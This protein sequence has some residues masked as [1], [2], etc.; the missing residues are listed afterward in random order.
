MN[1]YHNVELFDGSILETIDFSKSPLKQKY[2]LTPSHAGEGLTMRPLRSDDYNKGYLDLLGQLTE[3]GD[4]SQEKF[5]EQ[6]HRM[7]NCKNNYFVIIIEDVSN[8]KIVA[9]GTLAVEH[10]FI[11]RT[12]SRGRVEDIVVD[13]DYRRKHLGQLV[14]ETL[15]SL[16]EVVGCYKTSLECTENLI[17]FYGLFGFN[18]EEGRNY[19]C[20][21][22]FS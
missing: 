3:V 10:K 15:T 2:G 12:A 22:F 17:P 11:H 9:S 4:I 18:R 16:S 5:L 13:K 6:F 21:R 8:N 14:V 19:L 20:K 1:G 7:K